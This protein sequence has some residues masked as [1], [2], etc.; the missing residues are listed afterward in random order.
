[1]E[2]EPKNIAIRVSGM[3]SIISSIL[4]WCMILWPTVD[5][6]INPS[7]YNHPMDGMEFMFLFIIFV[8]SALILLLIELVFVVSR[9]KNLSKSDKLI[10]KLSILL[11][12]TIP[13]AFLVMWI[14][15]F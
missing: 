7:K 13:L 9:R 11:P 15:G 5:I 2:Q 6:L 12:I 1:M 4:A 10:F 3:L 8:S 14:L